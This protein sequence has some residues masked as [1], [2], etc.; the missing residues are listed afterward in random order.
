M[1]DGDQH[2]SPALSPT[3]SM[4]I[5]SHPRSELCRRQQS[6]TPGGCIYLLPTHHHADGEYTR[7]ERHWY[8]GDTIV[9]PVRAQE[10]RGIIRAIR[11]RAVEWFQRVSA[12]HSDHQGE[13]QS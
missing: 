13:R 6:A 9:L 4:S 2:E 1:P 12:F 11:N 10:Q 7:W 8:P 5:L 3:L